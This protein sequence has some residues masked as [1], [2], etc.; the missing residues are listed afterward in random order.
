MSYRYAENWYPPMPVLEIQLGYPEKSLALGP[1]TA[2][3]D[4]GADGTIIPIHLVERLDAPFTD[5]VRLRG[6]W[7]EWHRARMFT[8]DIGIGSLCL[9][10]VEV[11]GDEHGDEIILGR[12]VLNK[13]RL[14][15]D[16]PNALTKVLG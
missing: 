14:L 11:V 7:G 4:T 3:V 12:N 8:V 16:G 10:A 13:L 2:I 1:Y 9:P 6:Q 5:D 15:L